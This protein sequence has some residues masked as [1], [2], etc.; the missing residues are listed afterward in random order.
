MLLS[1][2]DCILPAK[3]MATY[4]RATGFVDGESLWV[5]PRLEHA[6]ILVSPY[7]GDKVAEA[8]INVAKASEKWWTEVETES[9]AGSAKAL[10]NGHEHEQKGQ[11]VKIPNGRPQQQ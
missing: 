6:A 5:M 7:W 1:E 9:E 10:E 11:E 3:K 8:I 4:L 2:N